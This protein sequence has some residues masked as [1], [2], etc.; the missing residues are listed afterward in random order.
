MINVIKEINDVLLFCLR[1]HISDIHIEPQRSGLIVRVRRNGRLA[2]H[3]EYEEGIRD[4]YLGRIK[5]MAQLEQSMVMQDGRMVFQDTD[6]RVSTVPTQWGEKFVLRLLW[7]GLQR[8]LSQLGMPLFLENRVRRSLQRESGL[9]LVT[10]PTGSGKTTTIYALI[11]CFDRISHNIVTIEDP[12]EYQMPGIT[13]IPVQQYGFAKILRTVLRQDPDI[14]FIGEIRDEE[15]ALIAVRA[16]MTGHL[17]LSTLHTRNAQESLTRLKDLG[18]PEYLLKNT[19]HSI[20]NQRLVCLR[21]K[22][23]EIADRTAIFEFYDPNQ[24]F[25]LSFQECSQELL[26]NGLISFDEIQYTC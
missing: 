4:Q 1:E 20:I 18:V 16:A 3:A 13:Q 17:V 9:I 14:I 12:I 7:S 2:V 22:D 8:D 19:I 6:I 26:T 15:T 11:H 5:V 23:G 24:E 21:K 10:G 25:I